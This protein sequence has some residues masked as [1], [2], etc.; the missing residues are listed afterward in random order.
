M[1][2]V[3]YFGRFLI[4]VLVFIFASWRTRGKENIPGRGPFLIVCNHLH[5]TDPPIVA[6]SIPL[7]CVFLAKEQ[8]FRD[9]W[10][11]FWVSNFGAISVSRGAGVDKEAFRVAEDWL[12]QGVPGRRKEPDR[13]PSTRPAGRGAHRRPH[14]CSRPPGKHHRDR[15]A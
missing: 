10:S 9:G 4:R 6:A 1:H 3:Y 7:K 5:L 2:W 14:G 11:R 12:H 15:K 13:P 8:L